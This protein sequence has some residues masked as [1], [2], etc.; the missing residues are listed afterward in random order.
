M[1]TSIQDLI[2]L[3]KEKGSIGIHDILKVSKKNV[4]EIYDAYN[5]GYNDSIGMDAKTYIAQKYI[6]DKNTKP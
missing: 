6:T 5:A 3:C 1:K 2:D 4:Q